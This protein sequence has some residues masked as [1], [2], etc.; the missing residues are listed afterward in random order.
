[1]R[2]LTCIQEALEVAKNLEQAA[3]DMDRLL[4]EAT[5]ETDTAAPHQRM[6]QLYDKAIQDISS[7]E[8]RYTP[9]TAQTKV[10]RVEQLWAKLNKLL[11]GKEIVSQ[12][13]KQVAAGRTAASNCKDPTIKK[14]ILEATEKLAETIP[15]IQQA[16]E[17]VVERPDDKTSQQNLSQLLEKAKELNSKRKA[18]EPKHVPLVRKSS[19]VVEDQQQRSEPLPT[20]PFQNLPKMGSPSMKEASFLP[21]EIQGQSQPNGVHPMNR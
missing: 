1:M 18:A 10:H 11:R 2:Q 14:D 4:K 16:I 13:E 19:V 5:E 21:K 3:A 6:G 9:Q 8:R 15:Q 20:Q 12:I 17:N 7:L